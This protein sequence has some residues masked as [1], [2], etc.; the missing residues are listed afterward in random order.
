MLESS[1]FNLNNKASHDVETI[2]RLFFRVE[3]MA[4]RC[5]STDDVRAE[6]ADDVNYG[7]FRY[8]LWRLM[9]VVTCACILAE[10]AS[11]VAPDFSVG[12][13]YDL[14]TTEKQVLSAIAA[15]GISIVDRFT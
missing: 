6:H 4:S 15:Q 12:T 11:V 8:I 5:D 7:R 3:P 9:A 10:V 2:D 1:Q 13:I 14:P